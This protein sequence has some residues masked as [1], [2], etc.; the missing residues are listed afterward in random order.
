MASNR[1]IDPARPSEQYRRPEECD[2]PSALL[3]LSNN[4]K[5][6][7]L[8]STAGLQRTDKMSPASIEAYMNGFY[9]Y[10]SWKHPLWFIGMEE[11]GCPK[12]KDFEKRVNVWTQRG[13]RELEDARSYHKAIRE[14][15]WFRKGARLQPTL[16]PTWGKLIRVYL[17]L[18]QQP[19]DTESVRQFQINHFGNSESAFASLELFPLPSVDR[20]S[21]IYSPIKD[22]PYLA[23]KEQ[24]KSFMYPKRA[25]VL[26]Q[27]IR[28]HQPKHVVC[29][30]KDYYAEW[31]GLVEN[32]LVATRLDKVFETKLDKTVVLVTPHPVWRAA[33]QDYWCEV[34]KLLKE[35]S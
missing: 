14:D 27:R 21:W 12:L 17:S 33:P 2:E 18:H 10:G 13:G 16:Q 28:L 20:H 31:E 4:E 34:G 25:K 1:S 24:Y 22:L 26:R 35:R 30:G 6:I 8:F 23:S 19:T 3:I 29:Y 11:G 15:R 32:T 7:D 5:R 9:G